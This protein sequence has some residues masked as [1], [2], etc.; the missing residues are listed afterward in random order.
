ME[1]EWEPIAVDDE[2][3]FGALPFLGEAHLFTA[4]LSGCERAVEEGHGP[5]ELALL[6]EAARAAR[7]MP[8]Q[9]PSSPQRLSRRHAVAGAP[10]SGGKSCQREPVTSM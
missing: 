1:T 5:I 9:T 7:Q 8:S 2:H 6:V 10:Y 3:P 4:L